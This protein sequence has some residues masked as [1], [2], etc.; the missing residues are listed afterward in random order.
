MNEFNFLNQIYF[1]SMNQNHSQLI[2]THWNFIQKN[3][4]DV[5]LYLYDKENTEEINIF[6]LNMRLLSHINVIYFE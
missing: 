3:T 5:L 4:M 6:T 2:T 1:Y